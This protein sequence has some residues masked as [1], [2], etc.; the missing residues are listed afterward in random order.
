MKK[1]KNS[2]I[3]MIAWLQ[4][5]R[6]R[7]GGSILVR[8]KTSFIPRQPY[9]GETAPRTHWIGGSL[10]PRAGLDEVEKIIDPTGTRIPNP[11][12]SNQ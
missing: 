11:R 1:S 8:G 7:N 12:S 9:P 5:G 10:D 4:T 6:P 3:L 2:V